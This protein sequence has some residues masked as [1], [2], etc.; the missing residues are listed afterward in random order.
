[1]YPLIFRTVFSRMNPEAAHHVAM[2]VIRLLG[3]RPAG[4]D[5]QH[6]QR[7]VPRVTVL[8]VLD[9]EQPAVAG[10]R[11]DVRIFLVPVDRDRFAACTREVHRGPVVRG[12]TDNGEAARSK[13]ETG[14][15]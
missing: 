7:H 5:A 1:M 11:G 10:Q 3:V 9:R 6:P 8:A 15:V 2:P 4:V 12:S 14:R 13:R